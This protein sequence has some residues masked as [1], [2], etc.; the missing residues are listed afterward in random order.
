MIIL[1][2]KI[3]GG[4][5]LKCCC[6]FLGGTL[7]IKKFREVRVSGP[8]GAKLREPAPLGVYDSFQ[9]KEIYQDFKN[10]HLRC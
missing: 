5:S 4:G 8:L 1:Y 9:K 7:P 2:Q 3:R 6:Q 10:G